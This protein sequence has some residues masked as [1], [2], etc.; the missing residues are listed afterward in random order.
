[1]ALLSGFGGGNFASSMSN[2]SFF[3]PKKIQ[4]YSLG[5]N[6]GLGN[7]G[8]TTMQIVIPLVMTLAIMGNPTELQIQVQKVQYLNLKLAISEAKW[9]RKWYF[10]RP[11]SE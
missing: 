11:L 7:F 5:M 6:A 2:I 3:F 1:L 4:G 10:Y 9:L 8:V